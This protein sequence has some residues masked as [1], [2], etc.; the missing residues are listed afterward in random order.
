MQML[1]L[2]T[3][4]TPEVHRDVG[5]Q[6]FLWLTPITLLAGVVMTGLASAFASY[7]YLALSGRSLEPSDAVHPDAG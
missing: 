2:L 4:M 6:L 1:T 5:L 7:S 3:P